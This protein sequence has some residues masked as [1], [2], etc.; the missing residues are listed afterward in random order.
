MMDHVSLSS[1]YDLMPAKAYLASLGSQVVSNDQTYDSI[2]R[3]S[4]A[5]N[6]AALKRK[7]ND[8]IV[9]IPVG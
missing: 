9:H 2:R 8:D 6:S 7:D 4:G 3:A 1:L 5:L